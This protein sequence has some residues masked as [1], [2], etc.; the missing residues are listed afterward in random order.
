MIKCAQY[1]WDNII[2]ADEVNTTK[3]YAKKAQCGVDLSVR[4]VK[5]FTNFGYTLKDKTF[6]APTE[7]LEKTTMPTPKGESV[8][9][10]Y[11]KPGTYELEL[12]EGCK[13][14]PNDTAMIIV[15]SSL[16][17]CAVSAYSG[18]YDAGF[19][20]QTTDGKIYPMNLRITVD[21]PCGFF[22]EENARVAQIV[23]FENEDTEMYMGQWAHGATISNLI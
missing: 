14:G 20:T 18:L 12:N 16:N 3:Q 1:I 19:D 13:L 2:I 5:R 15:R 4:N 7:V 9:G 17:R 8:T 6:A 11:L 23:I 10:Y 22:L 21:N